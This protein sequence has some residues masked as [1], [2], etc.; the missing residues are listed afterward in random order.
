M[1]RDDSD[2]PSAA[3]AVVLDTF[4]TQTGV[5]ASLTRSDDG[6]ELL[7]GA[8]RPGASAL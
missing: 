2:D 6:A 4:A 3:T 8:R 1:A 5:S 7:R